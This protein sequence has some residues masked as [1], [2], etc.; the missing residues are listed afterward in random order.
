MLA[1]GQSME[2]VPNVAKFK[3][4]ARKVEMNAV[5]L[6]PTPITKDNLN[7][8]IDAGWVDKAT[9]CAGVD[10]AAVAACK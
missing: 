6:A 10:A 8:V 9:V 5:L 3:D 2:E 4:G 1:D 7:A